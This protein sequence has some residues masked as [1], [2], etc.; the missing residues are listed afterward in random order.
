M[1]FL[2]SSVFKFSF[3]KYVG[4]V[5]HARFTFQSGVDINLTTVYAK[6]SRVGRRPLWRALECLSEGMAGLW[7]V[8]GDF[9]VVSSVEEHSGGSPVNVTNME[10]FISLMFACGLSSVD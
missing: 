4:Q 10:D 6:C 2:W 9:N 3:T 8:A 5:V 1:W 7:I